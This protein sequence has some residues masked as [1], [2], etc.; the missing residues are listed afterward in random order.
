MQNNVVLLDYEQHEKLKNKRI[1][2]YNYYTICRYCK[3]IFIQP[4]SINNTIITQN[5]IEN[6]LCFYHLECYN[7]YQKGYRYDEWKQQWYIYIFNPHTIP[8]TYTKIYID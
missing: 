4:S 5:I 6:T 8:T 7:F 3:N 1:G 2:P